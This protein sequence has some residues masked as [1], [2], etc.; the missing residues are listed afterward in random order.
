[1]KKTFKPLLATLVADSAAMGANAA[2]SLAKSFYL[3]QGNP[4]SNES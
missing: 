2:L 3:D 1:M 4:S